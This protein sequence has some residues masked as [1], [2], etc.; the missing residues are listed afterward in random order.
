MKSVCSVDSNCS[1]AEAII[2]VVGGWCSAGMCV[3][4]LSIVRSTWAKRDETTKSG[5]FGERLLFVLIDCKDRP[6]MI[7]T[8]R[9]SVSDDEHHESWSMRSW[10]PGRPNVWDNEHKRTQC[11]KMMNTKE[12]RWLRSEMMNT[13]KLSVSAGTQCLRSKMMNTGRTSAGVW[14]DYHW[15][16]WV[17]DDEHKKTQGL[18]DECWGTRCLRRGAGSDADEM[19][20][21]EWCLQ[22]NLLRR[23]YRD[24]QMHH[25]QY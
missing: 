17:W 19:P 11:L 23:H 14:D 2:V 15:K 12:T 25:P 16:T 5:C 3:F 9:L 21:G 1:M 24:F 8:W 6:E 22:V 18:D 10:T 20:R 7:N 4:G 13:S